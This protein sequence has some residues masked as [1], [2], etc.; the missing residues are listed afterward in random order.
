MCMSLPEDV[1]YAA[2]VDQPGGQR[3][4]PVEVVAG[5][6]GHQIVVAE[7][8]GGE[9]RYYPQDE[10]HAKH[11]GLGPLVLGFSLLDVLGHV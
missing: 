2:C 11:A 8:E 9:E 6:E 7:E 4:H 3:A 1:E 5:Q 10:P